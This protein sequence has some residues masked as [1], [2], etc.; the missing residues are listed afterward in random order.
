MLRELNREEGEVDNDVEREIRNDLA[1]DGANLG[2]RGKGRHARDGRDH[3]SHPE[4]HLAVCWAELGNKRAN[5]AAAS[6]HGASRRETKKAD[7]DERIGVPEGTLN[8][9]QGNHGEEHR[10]GDKV[11]ND[12][13]SEGAGLALEQVGRNESVIAHTPLPST[14]EKKGD[15]ANNDGEVDVNVVARVCSAGPDYS[16]QE[17]GQTSTEE[18]HANKIKRGELLGSSLAIFRKGSRRTVEQKAEDK[19]DAAQDQSQAKHPFVRGVRDDH[20]REGGA[21]EIS[22]PS[23]NSTQLLT[24]VNLPL[25]RYPFPKRQSPTGGTCWERSHTQRQSLFARDRQLRQGERFLQ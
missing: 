23:Q 25:G 15:E 21:S 24:E 7:T 12:G 16:H 18:S 6:E 14:K 13:E 5:E 1:S 22:L 10:A 20:M 17:N 11:A 2:V 9:P 4:E 19:A 8:W 3:H